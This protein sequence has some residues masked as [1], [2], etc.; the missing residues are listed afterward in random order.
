MAVTLNATSCPPPVVP[1]A[2]TSIAGSGDPPVSESFSAGVANGTATKLNQNAKSL[3]AGLTF[4]GGAYG[5]GSG[6]ALSAGVGLLCTVAIGYAVIGG[7]VEL[8]SAGSVVLTAASTNW[9]WLKQDGTLVKTTTTTKPTG[10]CVCLGAA[11]TDGSG[12]T[13]IETAGVVYMTA[14]GPERETADTGAPGD[15][16]DSSL[17][18]YTKTSDGYYLWNGDIHIELYTTP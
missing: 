17:R 6:L 9:I 1:G 7:V 12:V 4:G 5:I 13:A 10:N 18:L 11:V 15:S 3:D 14:I 2:V 8:A 16:P